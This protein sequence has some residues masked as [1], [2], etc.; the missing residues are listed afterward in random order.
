MNNFQKY[1]KNV[2]LGIY[3]I[4]IGMKITFSHLFKKAV[5]IQYPDERLQLPDRERNR[6]F[7]NMDDCIGCDQ[8]ARA[9]PVDCIYLETIKATP[10]D[11]V[12]RTGVTSNGKKK[13]LFVPTFTIDI[14]KCCYC[15]LCVFPC[16]TE[17]IYMTDVFE[18][19]EYDRNKFIYE[20]TDM[21]P[22]QIVEKKERL[23]AHNKEKEAKKAAAKAEA[24]A[25]AKEKAAAAAA[26]PKPE[27][28]EKAP[29]TP[30]SQKPEVKEK[31][32]AANSNTEPS[33]KKEDLAKPESKATPKSK[34]E[35]KDKPKE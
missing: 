29:G 20:F 26:N 23:E 27:T 9:C 31:S 3:T 11:V 6:L 32:A 7:V 21:T 24:E 18:F 13:A 33:A 15:Q 5:T 14:A 4:L 28:K 17:C 34:T 8:C 1:F 12:G 35:N 16:P 25:K 2:W 10:G 19:S 22:Q 30:A